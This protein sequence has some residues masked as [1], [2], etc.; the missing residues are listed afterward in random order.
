MGQITSGQ[1][2]QTVS[3][4]LPVNAAGM[5]APP[6][7][8]FPRARFQQHFLNGGP[9]GCWGGQLHQAT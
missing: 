5:R 4:A 8:V 3:M 7:L 2:G 1:R 9:P 6:H